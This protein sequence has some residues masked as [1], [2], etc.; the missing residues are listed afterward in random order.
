MEA[1]WRRCV[2]VGRAVGL[3]VTALLPGPLKR[4]VLRSV[5]GF[6]IGRN[7][8]IGI[9]TYFGC[10]ELAIEDHAVVGHLVAFKRCGSVRIGRH[11]VI[12]PLNLFRGGERIELDDYSQLLRMNI[13]NAIPNHDCYGVLDSTFALGYGAVVTSSHWI[14]FTD[15]VSIGRRSMLGGRNSS[16]WTHNRRR[17]APVHIGDFCY[18][19]S[20][21]RIAPGVT[22]PECSIV[23]MGSVVSSPFTTPFTVIGG[24]PARVTRALTDTDADTLFN[25]PRWDLPDEPLPAVPGSRSLDAVA[26][27]DRSDAIIRNAEGDVE[28]R[29]R[30]VV[31]EAAKIPPAEVDFGRSLIE[32]GIDS[33]QLIV[34]RE[35]LEGALQ[36]QFSDDVWMRMETPARIVSYITA[37]RDQLP[38]AFRQ[39]PAPTF[40]APRAGGSE[41]INPGLA[42]DDLEIGMPLTGR[43]NLAETPLLQRL[44][45]QRWRHI[46]DVMGVPSRQIVDDQGER[47]YA[48]FFYVEMAFPPERPM[49]LFG[50]N[51]RFKVASTLQRYGTSML[52]GTSYLLPD[53]FRPNGGSPFRSLEEAVAGG[54]PAVR[55]S[56]IFVKQF[57]GAE[58]LKKGRPSHPGFVRIPAVEEAPDSYTIVKRAEKDGHLGR[59]EPSWI[60]VTDGPVRCEYRLVPD[61]DLNGAGLV[62]FANYPMFLDI[63]ERDVL[64]S[65]NLPLS[66]D[67]VDRRTLVRRRSAY[68]NN[69]SSRDTLI[70][71]IEPWID[72]ST[73]SSGLPEP[74]DIRMHVTYRM[75]R[76]SD[77][78]L[79]MVS[80]AEKV[81]LGA[82]IADLPFAGHLTLPVMQSTHGPS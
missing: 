76:R 4:V 69:A 35:T 75:Y 9:A 61:R 74:C 5:F 24:S 49:G 38:P 55:L 20:E 48:T 65:A 34:L 6:R 62:Y 8:R 41:L 1:N 17:A 32:Q 66:D 10:D 27:I 25:K 47:L 79:M 59:P 22:I 33:L 2:R 77:G 63:C 60:P 64:V 30:H 43:N 78:R 19:G 14:D 11:A 57:A 72:L 31:A 7:V 36:V 44:G 40:A 21:V 80:T 39:A 13:I 73:L 18:M 50:E 68:L 42:V 70:I 67:L 28:G 15:R 37:C 81:I 3:G 12:G 56:N 58:W 16:I 53:T 29:V 54:V 82:T 52:D 23:A 45:D 46:S 26:A 51:D 71:E